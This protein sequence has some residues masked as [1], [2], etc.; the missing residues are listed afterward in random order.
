L[1]RYI[2][3]VIVLIAIGVARI[4]STYTVFN[5]AYDEPFHIANGMEWLQQG[6][7]TNQHRHPPLAGIVSALGPFIH[8]LRSP[9]R[10]KPAEQGESVIFEEGNE[11]L[12]AKNDYWLSLTLA[13]IGTLPFFVLACVVTFLWSRRWFCRGFSD[14]AGFWA[15]LL[16]VCTAPILGHAGL[17]TNDVACAAGAAFALYRF[18]RWLEQPDT[19]RW[20][21][22][23]FA[24]AFAIL[25]KYSNIPFLGACYVVG[26]AVASRGAFRRRAA[27]AGLAACVVLFLM[28][29]TYRFT[30]IPLGTVYGPH[31][32][33]DIILSTRPLL[34]S[35][36]NTVM[37]IP[38]PLTEAMLGLRD[39]FRHNAIGIDMYLLGQWSQSGW[40]Y[41]FPV[42]LAVKTPIGLLLLA[43][44]GCAFVLMRWRK[45]A[46][47]QRLSAI[48]PIVILLV[49]MLARI[50]LGVRHILAIYPLLAILGG[51]A[52]TALFRHSRPAAVVAM[53]LVAWVVVDSWRAHPD[54]LAHFNEFAGSHPEKILCESDLDWGQD[55]HRLSLRLKERG[56]QEFSIAY[57]GTALLH[58]ADLPHYELL[59]PT[60]PSRGYIAVSLHH[61]N[62]DYKKDGSF[63]WLKSYTPVE[64]IG[65]SIDLFYIP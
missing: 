37:A 27:Q 15:V 10:W 43:A 39:L 33:I 48:F 51:Y 60:Q 28:W 23:G 49:C 18:V 2:I 25:C 40:W 65:K 59:S 1:N 8:G 53:L 30:L 35:I 9:R 42:V 31:P 57:F 36:W 4:A 45:I 62:I 44:G 19:A 46:W 5:G 58:K 54:Y 47:Q 12:Y 34:R 61:L 16:L 6:T 22:W 52:V 55:L 41:F 13:R 17:A 20:L 56:V 64:R 50:D 38:L 11:I 21:W 63:A 26:F 7:F 24:T 3:G 14:A 32:R 29:A